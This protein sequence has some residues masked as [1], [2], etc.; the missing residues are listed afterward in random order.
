M[1]DNPNHLNTGAVDL[2]APAS[3]FAS[4]SKLYGRLHR[5][6]LLL[7]KYWW[8]PVLIFAAVLVPAFVLT[9]LTG[10][11]YESKARMWVPGKISVSENWTYTE[12]LVNFLGTQAALLESPAIQYRAL[13]RMQAESKAVPQTTVGSP[14]P[15]PVPFQVKVLEGAKSST[16]ELRAIGKD[17]SATRKFLDCLM[18]EY[19]NFKQESRGH[20]SS[21][22]ASSLD[23]EAAQLKGELT[24]AQNK[25]Q[26][27]Q[28]SNNVVLLQQQGSGAEN[29]LAALNRQL[30]VLRTEQ[31]LLDSLKPE[32]W[33]QTDAGP[34]AGDGARQPSASLAD[35]QTVLFQADQQMHL[36]MA[37]RD[38]LARFLRPEHPLIIKLD[39]DIATQRQIVQVAQDEAAKQLALRRQALDAQI[40]NLET[41]SKEWDAKA[42]E[43]TSQVAEFERLQQNVQRLQ[44][45]YDKSFGLIQNLDVAN[46]IEQ[47]NVG[48]LDPASVAKP[49]HRLLIHL[50]AATALALA[51]S[52]GLLLGLAVLRD[53][54]ASRAELAEHFA[55]PVLGQIPAIPSAASDWSLG[56]EALDQQRFEFMEAFRNLRATLLFRNNGGPR[57]KTI[58]ITSSLPGEGKS[59]VA[60][61][62]AATLAKGNLRVLLVD[63]DLRRP[64]LHRQFGVSNSPGLAELLNGELS[65]TDVIIPAGMENLTLL[66]AGQARRN[67]GDLMLSPAWESFLATVN[68]QFDFI[69]VDTPPLAAT[70]DAATLAPK[71]DGVLFVVQASATSARVARDALEVMRQ[72]HT[73]VLGLVFNRAVSSPCE[74]QYYQT[75]AQA[76]GWQLEQTGTDEIAG[77]PLSKTG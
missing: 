46:R 6:W 31:R 64:S 75:Y 40:K 26:A 55:E 48:I 12:E 9:V 71:A 16:L 5:W 65:A 20:A 17:P 49:T 43:T 54:F 24:A 7:R 23:A 22:A 38:E 50:A 70:D 18:A 21:L 14:P 77:H 69:L 36:L 37:K 4:A 53:D 13:A 39:Q 25:L 42:I 1:N 8:L 73:Q 11:T 72:R 51:L 35:S 59:T 44:A 47:E 29:Y 30:A 19:L 3:R 2:F 56:I 62:L 61:Y 10:P 58:V 28:A 68:P 74:R 33:V 67:P 60:L 57:P 27:F 34:A 76:Y 32:Q 15:A 41:T 63:G 66:T 45:A 52:F